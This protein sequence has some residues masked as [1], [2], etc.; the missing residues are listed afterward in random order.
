[1]PYRAA[2]LTH[3]PMLG[4]MTDTSAR[5]WIRTLEPGSFRIV[6]ETRLPLSEEASG[7]TGKTLAEQDNTGYVDLKG[8]KPG[9]R[10]YYGVVLGGRLVDTRVDFDDP[11]PSFRTFPDRET[12]RDEDHNPE[13][14][15]NICFS[16]GTGGCQ[17]RKGR[18][19]ADAPAFHQMWQ[20]HRDQLMFHFMNGDYIYEAMRDG[21]LSGFRNN[22]KLYMERGRGMS[23][24]QRHVPWLF[25]FDDHEMTGEQGYGQ[26][27]LRNGYWCERD[28][29]LRAW[30]EYAGWANYP[31]DH[32]A[33]LRFGTA[34]VS[35][36][37]N[38]LT[39]PDADFSDLDPGTV[40]TIQ[41]RRGEKNAGVYALEEVLGPHK[42]RVRPTFRAD[43][44]CRYT[45]GTHHYFD[46]K[47][48]NCHFFALDTRGERDRFSLKKQFEPGQDI[49]GKTQRQW[50]LNGVRQTDAD[51]VF[52][53]S[54]VP[55]LL[56][57]TAAHVGGTEDPK[58]D[59]YVGF[60]HERNNI[61]EELDK[62]SKPVLI[63]TGDVHNSFAIQ[64]SDNVWEFMC[65]PL[66]SAAHPIATAANPP[67]GGTFETAN[68]KMK[69]RWAAGW[70]TMSYTRLHSTIY[71]VVQVNN[72]LKSG[73]AEEPGYRWVAYDEPTVT[74]RF[75]DGYT[76]NL[77]YA[78]SISTIGL[79][80]GSE[81]D[82]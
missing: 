61:L 45:I 56:P 52:I 18:Q 51:F 73:R 65:G 12:Y 72:I 79:E 81:K 42:L 63:M 54:G 13:G 77:L 69:I 68:W 30:Y 58:G 14:L 10:Y 9:T 46:W 57:H 39:D 60:A 67:Y 28:L 71:A 66:N 50:L 15:Y 16:V 62:L 49:L 11:W 34:E 3:G 74:V 31:E 21:Q 75:H 59:T 47:M 78:E 8:L 33:L 19:Y 26:V 5:V 64:A 76:G 35:K 17:N 29:A 2:G 41:V 1:M 40:S 38:V 22:Y 7:V 55:W 37:G 25:V 43:E 80:A 44:N 70:P 53:M 4:R 20:S 6:Y 82:R 27:G 24:L 32:R 36:G 23:K 48:G